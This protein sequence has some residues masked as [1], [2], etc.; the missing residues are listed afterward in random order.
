MHNPLGT[1]RFFFQEAREGRLPGTDFFGLVEV[2]TT[3]G[4]E[5]EYLNGEYVKLEQR[6]HA[7][8]TKDAT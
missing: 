6:E 5:S 7:D 2:D 4:F 3:P 1:C 8:G